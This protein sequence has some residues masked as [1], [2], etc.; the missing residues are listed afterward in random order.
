M[1]VAWR[2]LKSREVTP[3]CTYVKEDPRGGKSAPKINKYCDTEC[4]WQV[5]LFFFRFIF[6]CYVLTVFINLAVCMFIFLL[7]HLSRYLFSHLF[8]YPFIDFIPLFIH[9]FNWLPI[10]FFLF[11]ISLKFSHS[12]FFFF[13]YLPHM[14]LCRFLLSIHILV[15]K[16]LQLI[17]NST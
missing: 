17:V 2:H 15:L 6:Q 1:Y 14:F 7:I 10:N 9:L 12:F 11:K 8:I 3:A 4:Y 13:N 5:G 16:L